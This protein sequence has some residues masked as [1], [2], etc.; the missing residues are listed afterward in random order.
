MVWKVIRTVQEF[1][2]VH[3]ILSSPQ[4]I[5]NPLC[6]PLGEYPTPEQSKAADQ[7]LSWTGH[8]PQLV[9]EIRCG[10]GDV[11]GKRRTN[12]SPPKRALHRNPHNLPDACGHTQQ[13][14]V[15]HGVPEGV[16]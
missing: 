2:F 4:H 14:L 11:L 6:P 5:L 16:V 7:R 10:V 1:V 13:K 3:A 8:F 12:S 15:T 9:C